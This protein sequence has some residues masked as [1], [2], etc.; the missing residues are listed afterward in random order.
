MQAPET[1]F[2]DWQ[3][4]YSTEEACRAAI[5]AQR[6]PQGF[7]CPH[8]GHD[9]AWFY[10][11][12]DRYE[13]A[14]CYRQTYLTPGTV[15]HGSR[16]PLTKWF[17]TLY[18][19]SA[20]EGGISALRL[21]KIIG[22]HWRTAYNR[23][24]ALRAAMADRD[25][26][27]RLTELIEVDDAYIGSNKTGKAGRGG[28][29]TPVPV[30]IET[31]EDG[32]PGFVAIEALDS[33]AKPNIIDFAK[34]ACSPAASVT[35][36]PSSLSG[37][38]VTPPTSPRSPCLR[39]PMLGCRGCM[40]S[41][42]TSSGSYSAPSTVPCARTLCRSTSMNSSTGSTADSG[43]TRYPTACSLCASDAAARHSVEQAPSR[44]P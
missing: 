14:R 38:A 39:R 42:P 19:V 18:L 41:S 29:R 1:S 32:K 31:T 6:W 2:Y 13:C 25:N 4:R 30:A 3:K 37:L 12:R 36:T 44:D 34:E 5:L 7:H 17:W 11:A 10:A 40:S 33:L 9:H 43:K 8:C 24:R 22:V 20:D 26:H 35:Q 28:G 16:V 15:F 21:S 23:L 27:Y